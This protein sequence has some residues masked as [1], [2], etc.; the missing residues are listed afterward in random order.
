MQPTNGVGRPQP[1][2][3]TTKCLGVKKSCHDDQSNHHNTVAPAATNTKVH[4]HTIEFSHNT[5]THT[6]KHTRISAPACAASRNPNTTTSQTQ[7][8]A[9]LE[10]KNSERNFHPNHQ[11]NQQPSN[12][13]L[14]TRRAVSATTKNTTHPTHTPQTPSTHPQNTP[15]NTHNKRRRLQKNNEHSPSEASAGN[16]TASP[17]VQAVS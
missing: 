13:S 9:T 17:P 16:K 8:R 15:T 3:K 1:H 6:T 11:H 14:A 7:T 4:W 5:R 12:Y 2:H 10:N